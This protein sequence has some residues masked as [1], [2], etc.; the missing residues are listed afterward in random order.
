MSV[1]SGSDITI[2][3]Q[4]SPPP[5]PS[6]YANG[7]AGP[8]MNEKEG[9][10]GVTNVSIVDS[11]EDGGGKKTPEPRGD[12]TVTV[13]FVNEAYQDPVPIDEK[14][15]GNQKNGK[16]GAISISVAGAANGDKMDGDHTEIHL[17]E[18]VN[19]ELINMNILN[20]IPD[21]PNSEFGPYD[22]L[23]EYFV[24]VNQH[25]KFLRSEKLYVTKD[26]RKESRWKKYVCWLIGATILATIVT[27][28]VLA[29]IGLIPQKSP[30]RYTESVV[31][32]TPPESPSSST[33]TDILISSSP[34]SSLPSSTDI[35]TPPSIPQD[36]LYVPMAADVEFHITDLKYEPALNDNTSERFQ[37]LAKEIQD[38]IKD[39]MKAKVGLNTVYSRISKFEPGSVFVKMR[40]GWADA[41]VEFQKVKLMLSNVET[42][43]PY[44][45]MPISTY[46]VVNYCRLNKNGCSQNCSFDYV[47]M[48]FYCSC[49]EDMYYLA[50]DKKVCLP[51]FETSS[52]S[53][54]SSTTSEEPM[55]E[56]S[57]SA[58]PEVESPPSSEDT[59][60]VEESTQMP[61]QSSPDSSDETETQATS[62]PHEDQH[63][64]EQEI[65]T[66]SII[67]S[68]IEP[69]SHH[70]SEEMIPL[71]STSTTEAPVHHVSEEVEHEPVIPI[72]TE[73]TTS[74]T[75]T[76]EVP[77]L[78]V[79]SE[80]ARSD[81]PEQPVHTT[82]LPEQESETHSP[83]E[84]KQELDSA[85]EEISQPNPTE[86]AMSKGEEEIDRTEA[87]SELEAVRPTETPEEHAQPEHPVS[88]ENITSVETGIN[89]GQQVSSEAI[90]PSEESAEITTLAP[91]IS[92]G[93]PQQSEEQ[94]PQQHQESAEQPPQQPE[95]SSEQQPQQPEESA[96]QQPQQ[97]EE[98]VEQQPQQHQEPVEQPTTSHES[99]EKVDAVVPAVLEPTTQPS[100]VSAEEDVGTTVQPASE[101]EEAKDVPLAEEDNQH[102]ITPMDILNFSSEPSSTTP[103][104]ATHAELVLTTA[105]STTTTTTSTEASSEVVAPQY[106]QEEGRS[107]SSETSSQTTNDTLESPID[108][109]SAL[110]SQSL[111]E[112]LTQNEESVTEGQNSLSSG[113]QAVEGN[114]NR[115]PRLLSSDSGSV[116][117]LP[118]VNETARTE[119]EELLIPVVNQSQNVTE[120]ASVETAD[121]NPRTALVTSKSSSESESDSREIVTQNVQ[122]NESSQSSAGNNL[123]AQS[124][125][126]E[127]GASQESPLS[128]SE[129]ISG[130]SAS[131]ETTTFQPK[132]LIH[133]IDIN[134]IG[135]LTEDHSVSEPVQV[136]VE[137][138][139]GSEGT[140][141]DKEKLVIESTDIPETTTAPLEQANEDEVQTNAPPPAVEVEEVAA[142][143]SPPAS[144]S[145]SSS[146]SQSRE[147]TTRSI[148]SEITREDESAEFSNRDHRD[149]EADIETPSLTSSASA[150]SSG[151]EVGEPSDIAI[152]TTTEEP[153]TTTTTS[154]STTTT[155]T[156][157]TPSPPPQEI[158]TAVSSEIIT[159]VQTTTS[160]S[161][162]TPSPNIEKADNLN[163]AQPETSIISNNEDSSSSLSN[164]SASYSASA[165]LE[166]NNSYSQ[167]SSE[168]REPSSSSASNEEAT[169]SPSPSSEDHDN[170]LT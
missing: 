51:L 73:T 57:S 85:S 165:S 23:D 143:P 101:V 16:N 52:S 79:S 72:L 88:S 168:L 140:T 19:P 120:S 121:E 70:H 18:A 148:T 126:S 20:T 83:V 27:V 80:E 134:Y 170:E 82:V 106:E 95:E 84:E 29:G 163:Q 98:Q 25:K 117:L 124:A 141:N 93:H 142:I 113:E 139:I 34:G 147:E 90:L 122:N 161:T 91:A 11:S 78:S 74:T 68:E 108:N 59:I 132:S 92:E 3:I 102:H 13:G 151:A 15:S 7:G 96:E 133:D 146:E 109:S 137:T 75:T 89:E 111:T 77:T 116:E 69:V 135:N 1:S 160:T 115:G 118:S 24:P 127:S 36:A 50:A 149:T 94:Q 112:D 159:T 35:N 22:N 33:P 21:K 123:S 39:I 164:E 156:T 86:Q 58:S 56:I 40:I 38:E 65:S 157:T 53:T 66:E 71:T 64:P 166:N 48:D 114:N 46:D 12:V 17:N 128:E 152:T 76:T 4:D 31:G 97:H 9:K 5:P 130:E 162:T 169:L 138:I 131:E 60:P 144:S 110:K 107:F 103:T 154:T 37:E 32:T 81:L 2:P 28:A 145:S 45:I 8:K 67:P 158:L 150:E 10:T 54:T 104:P 136:E 41:S 105:A 153:L 129:S 44:R 26:K 62:F 61:E 43:G 155:T 42:V 14:K 100:P 167:E 30:N 125:S 47:V 119:R 55:L 49:D 87:R 6:P 63:E 99:D